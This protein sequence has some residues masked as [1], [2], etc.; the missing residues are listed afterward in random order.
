MQTH[1]AI[2]SSARRIRDPR[3]NCRCRPHG[4]DRSR[5]AA[6]HHQRPGQCDGE[7]DGPG[8]V[9]MPRPSGRQTIHH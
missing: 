5:F 6:D 9:P 8:I 2:G 7:T 1:I 3:R 4:R